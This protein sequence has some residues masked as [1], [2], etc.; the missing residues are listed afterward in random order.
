MYGRGCLGLRDIYPIRPRYL[1]VLVCTTR[2]LLPY[3][4]LVIALSRTR[5]QTGVLICVLFGISAFCSLESSRALY[6]VTSEPEREPGGLKFVVPQPGKTR[7]E[8]PVLCR[9]CR[10][11]RLASF[12]LVQ[13]PSVSSHASFVGDNHGVRGSVGDCSGHF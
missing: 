9:I 11:R 12:V 6:L 1:S 10:R 8:G 3:T 7:S 13:T 5:T 2:R 4:R